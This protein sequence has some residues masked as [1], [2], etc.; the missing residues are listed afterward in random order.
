MDEYLPM[1][2]AE[3]REHVQELNLAVVQ[4]EETSTTR[5]SSTRSSGSRTP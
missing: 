3:G 5:T 1:F 4:I 2:L